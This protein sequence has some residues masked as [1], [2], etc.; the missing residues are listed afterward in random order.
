[1]LVD[2]HGVYVVCHSTESE[3]HQA[4]L[5]CLQICPTHHICGFVLV[6]VIF[7][8]SSSWLC[9][10][11]ECSSLLIVGGGG[12]VGGSGGRDKFSASRLP[13]IRP[14]FFASGMNQAH[15][16]SRPRYVCSP[17]VRDSGSIAAKPTRIVALFFLTIIPYMSVW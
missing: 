12:D 2:S 6:G 4:P 5:S 10:F 15:M 3:V 17:E 16:L 7:G 11:G 8:V 13:R 1:M 14:A 9:V